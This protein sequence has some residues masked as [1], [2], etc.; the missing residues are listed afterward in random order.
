M[1]TEATMAHLDDAIDAGAE[2]KPEL[3]P[4]EPVN[5]SIG[6]LWIYLFT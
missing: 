2:H 6:I 4:C 3:P 5:G 1:Y